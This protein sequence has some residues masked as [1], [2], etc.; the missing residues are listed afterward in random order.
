MCVVHSLLSSCNLHQDGWTSEELCIL[1]SKRVLHTLF[2]GR[3]NF[4][5]DF[6]IFFY[7]QIKK[8]EVPEKSENKQHKRHNDK[9][10]IDSEMHRVTNCE[11]DRQTK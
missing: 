10:Q 2:T 7:P 9:R 8:K 5:Q 11:K 4:F 6:H 3:N 1:T